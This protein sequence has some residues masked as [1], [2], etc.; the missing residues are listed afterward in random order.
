MYKRQGLDTLAGGEGGDR[1]LID[2]AG[3]LVVEGPG[4]GT[5]VVDAGFGVA[6]SY[7]LPDNVDAALLVPTAGC[8]SGSP[9]S[10][11][12]RWLCLLYTSRCV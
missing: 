7:T 1:Y 12:R 6:G 11:D 10:S 3:D 2:V 5:D 8:A 9:S 4:Q